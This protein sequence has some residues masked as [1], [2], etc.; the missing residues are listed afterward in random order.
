[1]TKEYFHQIHT[2]ILKKTGKKYH[3]DLA[4][5]IHSNQSFLECS[6]RETNQGLDQTVSPEEPK[7]KEVLEQPKKKPMGIPNVEPCFS[8]K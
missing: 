3:Q 2:P 7:S 4:N 6:Y 1:L 5:G 8:E